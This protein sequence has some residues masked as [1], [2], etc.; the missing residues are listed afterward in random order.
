MKGKVC[1]VKNYDTFSRDCSEYNKLE[2]V[3]NN[4]TLKSP[5]RYKYFVSDVYAD[6]GRG[7]V[8]TTILAMNGSGETYQFLDAQKRKEIFERDD[9]ENVVDEILNDKY[10][11]DRA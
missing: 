11:L 2:V 1:V 6:F 10:C 7:K 4:L 3:A 8:W 9:L 5:R